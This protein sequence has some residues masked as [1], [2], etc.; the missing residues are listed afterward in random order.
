MGNQVELRER[1]RKNVGTLG[2]ETEMEVV[3]LVVL[4]GQARQEEV[5]VKIT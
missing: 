2:N 3:V 4:S 5:S 1:S